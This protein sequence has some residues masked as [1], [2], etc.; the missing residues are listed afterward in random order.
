MSSFLEQNKYNTHIEM[1]VHNSNF[2]P[3]L[4]YGE[5]LVHFYTKTL[6]EIIE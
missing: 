4:L 3:T 5:E 6:N 1:N 2:D